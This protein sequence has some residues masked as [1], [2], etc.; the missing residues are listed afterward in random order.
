[1]KR[2]PTS[3]LVMMAASDLTRHPQNPRRGELEP[4]IESIATNGFYGAL[5]VQKSTGFVIA[6]NHRFLA[7]RSLGM[8]EFPAF[9]LDVNDTQAKKI[10]LADNRTSDVAGYDEERLCDLLKAVDEESSLV[11]TGYQ[12]DDLNKLIKLCDTERPAEQDLKE[13]KAA[14]VTFNLL[15]IRFV[16]QREEYIQWLE[17]IRQTAGFNKADIQK[18]ILCRLGL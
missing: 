7:G 11:G 8:T 5:L 13:V 17:E 3:G 6:G 14:N 2:V 10:M 4:I 16:V 9:V 18:E 15:H 12:D 1:V